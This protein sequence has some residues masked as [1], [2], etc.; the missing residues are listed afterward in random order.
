[1]VIRGHKCSRLIGKRCPAP[2]QCTKAA[3]AIESPDWRRTVQV[4]AK[5]PNYLVHCSNISSR[6]TGHFA[7]YRRVRT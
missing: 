5:S 7:F 4:L 3:R 1:M 2:K 6:L